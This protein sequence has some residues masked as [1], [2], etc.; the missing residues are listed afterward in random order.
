VV[1]VVYLAFTGQNSVDG[2]RLRPF[3]RMEWH[4]DGSESARLQVP[5]KDN[6]SFILLQPSL[7]CIDESNNSSA[8]FSYSSDRCEVTLVWEKLGE[9]VSARLDNV[10]IPSPKNAH[11]TIDHLGNV[12]ADGERAGSVPCAVNN[13]RESNDDFT[14]TFSSGPKIP[15]C[16]TRIGFPSGYNLYKPPHDESAE[17][18]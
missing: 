9:S 1:L 14:V 6:F 4:F 13:T 16:D 12:F 3:C 18:P 5:T 7:A 17:Q 11:V 15:E 8:S 10:T 2:Y